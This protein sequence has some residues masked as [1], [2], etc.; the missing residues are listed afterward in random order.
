MEPTYETTDGAFPIKP[1]RKIWKGFAKMVRVLSLNVWMRCCNRGNG[2]YNRH[3]TVVT[4]FHS[5]GLGGATF[6]SFDSI[7][8]SEKAGMM[9]NLTS[10]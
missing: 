7:S 1:A 8:S 5:K 9:V 3:D 4:C 6:G 10:F 2:K